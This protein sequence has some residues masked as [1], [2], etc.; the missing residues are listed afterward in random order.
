MNPKK[1]ILIISLIL[2]FGGG[3][4]AIL[5]GLRGWVLIIVVLAIIISS[6]TFR[7]VMNQRLIKKARG[8]V[9]TKKQMAMEVKAYFDA[10]PAIAKKF[11]RMDELS[12]KG[13][14]HDA[15]SLANSIKNDD[16]SPIIKRYVEY[17]IEKLKRV[18]KHGMK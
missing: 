10:H 11:L 2:A 12:K 4:V 16:L 3:L 14:V 17:R 13:R 7:Y 9:I 15:I 18:K 6:Q 8:E 5:S 1:Q